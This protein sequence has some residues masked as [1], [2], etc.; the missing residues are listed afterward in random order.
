MTGKRGGSGVVRDD[1]KIIIGVLPSGQ[2][3]AASIQSPYFCFTANS[4]A[5]LK[6]KT[7]RAVKFYLAH[8]EESRAFTSDVTQPNISRLVPAKTIDWADLEVA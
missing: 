7:L 3:F 4:E 2:H 5:N 1:H 6:A 8:A